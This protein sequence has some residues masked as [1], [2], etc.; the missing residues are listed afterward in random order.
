MTK[1]IVEI[2][3]QT[4]LLS[5]NAAI[6]AARA[7]EAGRGFAVVA[8]EV[9]KL[10]DQ[11]KSSSISI[12]NII[13]KIQQ[14]TEMTAKEANSASL[15]ITQ[16]MDAVNKT[17]AAFR[18]IYSGM[19]GLF[20]QV[21]SV[22]KTIKSILDMKGKA[23]SS[24]ENISAVSEETAATTKEAS[25]NTIEQAETSERL[26]VLARELNEL[27]QELSCAIEIFKV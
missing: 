6:E 14:K 4:N 16:Q 21:G 11:T 13:N 7:G 22:E 3:E 2:A 17:D 15:I 20:S 26:A 19:E 24:I 25:A 8:E 12:N 23:L 27:A 18:M 10:A 1:V 5:L 9:R